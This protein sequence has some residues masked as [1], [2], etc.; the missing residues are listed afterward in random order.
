MVVGIVVALFEIVVILLFEIVVV[1]FHHHNVNVD[2]EV[3]HQHELLA[4][5][6]FH[7]VHILMED[8]IRVADLH[9]V[10]I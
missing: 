8:V 10:K 1:E 4:Q 9:V 5:I 2:H 7:W 6:Q 3:R